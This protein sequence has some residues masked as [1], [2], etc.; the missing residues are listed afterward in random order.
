M[1]WSVVI[2]ACAGWRRHA[3]SLGGSN[4]CLSSAERWP[5]EA[6]PGAWESSWRAWLSRKTR[7]MRAQ[8]L[9]AKAVGELGEAAPVSGVPAI[10]STE[11]SD[12]EEVCTLTCTVD[13]E[14]AWLFEATRAL[15][16]QLGVHGDDAQVEA[17]LAEGQA[18]LLAALPAGSPDLERLERVDTAQRMTNGR[19]SG[20]VHALTGR[21]AARNLRRHW[22]RLRF[23]VSRARGAK[24][25]GR[26][27]VSIQQ[28]G[29]FRWRS[30]VERSHR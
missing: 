15:L 20:R 9:Q 30:S 11:P 12:G 4:R 21:R 1:R 10:A 19:H 27:E 8:V 2:E 23:G 26:D 6:Y 29:S 28:Q 7:Q 22:R 3:A 25:A 17:L 18:T 5:S 16:G 24:Q 13:Q 14:E